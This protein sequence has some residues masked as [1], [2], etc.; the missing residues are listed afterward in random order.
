VYTNSNE[1]E[2]SKRFRG[3]A[4]PDA[5]PAV[6]EEYCPNTSLLTELEQQQLVTWNATRQDYPCDACVPQLVAMQAATAPDAVALVAGDQVLSYRELN[7]RANQLAHHLQTL[8]VGPN[9]LVSLCLER[10]SDMVVGLLGILK[11]GG[12][13]IPLDPTYPSERLTF[14]LTDAQASVLVTQKYL[15]SHLSSLKTQVVCLDADAALLTRQSITDPISTVTA[16]DLA[17]VIYTSGSTGRPKGVE[18]TH[19][20]LLNLVFWH[21]HAFEVTTADRATQVASPAFDATGWELWPYLTIGASIYLP[22]EDTRVIPQLLRD[23]L[24]SRG[25]TITFL[26]TALAESIM[27]LQWPS[28]TSLRFLLTGADTLHHYPS[29]GLPFV[30]VNNYGPTEATVVAT[31]GQVLPREH[32]DMP[33]SIGRPIANTQ[34][35]ILDE[36]LRQVPIGEVGE[37]YIGGA[38]VARGYLNRPT[39]TAEKFIPHPFSDEPGARLYKTGDLARY[40]PDGQIAFLGRIDHQVK[41]RGFRVEL[42]EIEAA[43][44]QHPA[45]YHAVVTTGDSIPGEKHLVAYIVLHPES[46]I[47]TDTLRATLARH[48]PDYMIPALFVQLEALPLTPNGKVD[49][50]ALPAPDATNMMWDR[51][52]AA[53]R[54]PLEDRL[55]TIVASLLGLQKVGIDENF[56][57]LGGHSLLAAQIILQVVEEFGVDIPLRR[58]FEA[59]TVHQLATEIE[60]LIMA[61][62]EAMSDDEIL[63]LLEHEQT[64]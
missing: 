44:N 59:P 17:Y 16:E 50:A 35:Y 58:L 43:L 37:L 6:R 49:R 57:L 25:I 12:A 51:A 9:V 54:T 53:P 26:P 39:L 41:I 40:L 62:V 20:N 21:Q 22:D 38:G 28:S 46:H 19:R 47:T 8:G 2:M 33:P 30:L 45:V 36:C 5:P 27:T 64:I 4:V 52:I 34:I 61:K 63:R 14:M 23:W 10:S 32:A 24:V 42:G 29:P 13:Y 48:L 60:R 31:S 11:A 15:A 56:F 1:M 7:Q 3:L 18:I 55:A